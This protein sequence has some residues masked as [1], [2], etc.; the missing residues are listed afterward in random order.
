MAHINST[1]VS[2]QHK[3]LF[4]FEKGFD[5]ESKMT[6]FEQNWTTAFTYCAVYVVVIFLGQ[7]YMKNRPKFDLRI[8]LT[9]WSAS[10]AIFS[11][12]GSIRLWAD[13]VYFIQRYGFKASMCDPVF[14]KGVVGFWSWLFVLSKLPELGDTLFIILRK[15]KLIFLHWYHHCTVLLYA[16]YTYACYSAQARYFVLM[17]FTVHALMYTYYALKASKIVRIP[18]WVNMC[19]TSLQIMQMLCGCVVNG[20]AY[21]F[22][23]RG[24]WCSTTD[25]NLK[26]SFLMYFSYL[27][28]FTHFFYIAYLD[29]KK[30]TATKDSA[31]CKSIDRRVSADGD[32]NYI[33]KEQ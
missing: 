9:I 21:L 30:A 2:F 12:F 25:S 20:Y 8:P 28:L 16:W 4:E 15:Q 7:E 11:W 18:S 32:N 33:K 5:H 14:Y 13:Y 6:W 3:T 31:S 24:E 23:K 17:N 10:L 29:K 1:R 27:V 22:R 26:V 19:I